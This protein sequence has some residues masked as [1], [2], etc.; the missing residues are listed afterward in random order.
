MHTPNRLGRVLLFAALTFA[1]T[2]PMWLV[3]GQVGLLAPGLPVAAVAVVCPALAAWIAE[4]ATGGP[5]GVAAWWTHAQPR[6]AMRRDGLLLLAGALPLGVTL[7]SVIWQ[8]PA[9]VLHAHGLTPIALLAFVPV[10]LIGAWLEE[11]GWSAL[12]AETL[13]KTW[14]LV[15]T[16]LLIGGIWALWHLISL[17][18]VGR[19]PNWIAWWI[20]GTLATRVTLVWLYARSD[21]DIRA[22]VLFHASDNFCWQGQMTLG[23]EFDPRIHGILMMVIATI[24]IAAN[25]RARNLV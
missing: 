25:G 24:V 23:V 6:T 16:A 1:F 20:V 19:S 18:Q 10:A 13:L 22:P 21:H 9:T 17:A 5:D 11:M 3:S 4:R 15:P 2:A 14:P 7:I 12:V 8:S